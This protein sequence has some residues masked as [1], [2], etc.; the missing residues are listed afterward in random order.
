[1]V[2]ITIYIYWNECRQNAR[3]CARASFTPTAPTDSTPQMVFGL[4]HAD[5]ELWAVLYT[6]LDFIQLKVL[7]GPPCSHFLYLPLIHICWMAPSIVTQQLYLNPEL[8]NSSHILPILAVT[9]SWQFTSE[10]PPKISSL[11]SPSYW[12]QFFLPIPLW[13]L[14]LLS[15]TQFPSFL[16]HLSWHCLDL[17]MKSQIWSVIHLHKV[18]WVVVWMEPRPHKVCLYGAVD[19][20]L[21]P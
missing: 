11:P 2:I 8:P 6:S 12:L 18:L 1:M 16:F 19:S 10:T 13:Q 4:P 15:S 21:H 20:N 14:S 17:L 3:V 5:L 7:K 9:K